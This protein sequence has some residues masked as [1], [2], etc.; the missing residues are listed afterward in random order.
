MIRLLAA[1]LWLAPRSFRERRHAELMAFLREER[2]APRHQGAIGAL[3]FMA[4]M[5]ADLAAT[6][7]RLRRRQLCSRVTRAAA[8]RDGW[9]DGRRAEA[10]RDS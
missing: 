6:S 1:V 7:M 8:R 10:R 3:R 4:V 2:Q 5:A 9:K